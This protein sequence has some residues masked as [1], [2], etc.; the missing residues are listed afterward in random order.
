MPARVATVRIGWNRAAA[1]PPPPPAIWV[2]DAEE[3]RRTDNRATTP[4][5]PPSPL[6]IGGAGESKRQKTDN[7]IVVPPPPQVPAPNPSAQ[8]NFPGVP[9]EEEAESST[10]KFFKALG[11]IAVTVGGIWLFNKMSGS[12]GS[13]PSSPGSRG[14]QSGQGSAGP[15]RGESLND[16]YEK[17]QKKERD[18]E[19]KRYQDYDNASKGQFWG[20]TID[21]TAR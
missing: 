1:P 20:N 15:Y 8:V 12:G 13:E 21:G 2:S 5:P 9:E 19:E 10:K 16:E 18:A 6:P 14:F 11:I 7:R 4:P 17:R 3:Q